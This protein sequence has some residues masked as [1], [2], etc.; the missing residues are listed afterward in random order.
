MHRYLGTLAFLAGG[1]CA[2]AQTSQPV[3]AEM[4]Q[5]YT[6]RKGDLLKAADRMPAEDY[7]FKPNPKEMSFGSS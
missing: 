7:D 3:I 1:A 2:V 4:N 6:I 5:F